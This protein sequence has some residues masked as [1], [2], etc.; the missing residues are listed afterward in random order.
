CNGAG[1]LCRIDTQLFSQLVDRIATQRL[2]HM[3]AGNLLIFAIAE[4]GTDDIAEL[5]L[6]EFVQNGL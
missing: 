3:I 6:T 5:P 4:S 2:L 1:G